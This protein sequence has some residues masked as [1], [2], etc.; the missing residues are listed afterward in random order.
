MLNLLKLSI[1]LPFLSA[2]SVSNCANIPDIEACPVELPYSGDGYCKRVV[3]QKSRRIPKAQWIKERRTMVCLPPA[4]YAMLK[5]ELYRSCY[6]NKCKQALD[7][8]GEV[9]QTLD[10]AVKAVYGK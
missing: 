3:S 10:D 1:I 9:F 4:S 8:V 5:K 2:L 7:S 6:D